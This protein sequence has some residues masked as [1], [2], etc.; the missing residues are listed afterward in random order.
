GSW[1]VRGIEYVD[2]KARQIYFRACGKETGQDP[3][4]IHYY[5][6]NFDGSGLVKLTEGNGSH[7]VSFSPD[8]RFYMDTYSRVDFPPVSVLRRTSDRQV[9]MELGRADIS[10]LLKTGWPMPEPFVAK[11]RDGKTDIYGVIY[12]PSHFDE[13]KSYPVIEL[14]YAGPHGSHVPKTFRTSC[15][16]QAMAELGFILVQMDGMGTAYRSKAFHDVCWQNVGDAG[17]PDRI[18]WIKAAAKK[19]SYMDISKVGIHGMSAGGQNSLGA[20]LFHP[21]FYKVAVSICGC[22]DNRMDKAGWNEQ[23]MGYPVGPHYAEQS[24]V[25]N[26]HKLKGE[27]LL[28]VGELDT[29][30]PPQSTLQVVDALITAKKDFDML[31]MPGYG[32]S[33]GL[34][35][36][37]RLKRDFFVKH[38]LGVEPPDWNK[39]EVNK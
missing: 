21:D 30:V 12:R 23:W 3:Y 13:T 34:D 1:V 4:L 26:A 20:L 2:E 18:A 35:Y 22:H 17:F 32:H 37:V 19:Y 5:R 33:G 9:V 6:I 14:I 15:G 29:N 36:G 31:V 38:L 24:N 11:G 10:D 7:S 39:L 16:S 27:L 8:Y 25:T 28:I